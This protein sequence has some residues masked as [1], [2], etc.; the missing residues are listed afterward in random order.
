MINNVYM[1]EKLGPLEEDKSS[2]QIQA[3]C[4]GSD[5]DI[6]YPGKGGGDLEAK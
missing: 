4:L 6:F 2:W 1:N 3:A 5:P